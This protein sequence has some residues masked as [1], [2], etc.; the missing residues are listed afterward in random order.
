MSPKFFTANAFRKWLEKN[1]HKETEVVVGFYKVK[2]GKPSMSWSESVDEALCFGW[3]DG[4]RTSIDAESYKIRFTPR[5]AGSIWSAVN[6]RKM[7]ELTKAG[8][9]T[10][11]G[12]A[13]FEK[14]KDD[15]SAIYAHENK[16]VEFP[17]EIEKRFKANKKAW[18]YFQSLAPS[19]RKPSK[20]WVL[21]AKQEATR[22]K[23]LMKLIADSE[24]GIN[25]WKD[26]KYNKK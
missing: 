1:H 19:Y 20:N 14:R 2:S 18:Q 7:K 10:E 5:K 23:R 24:A 3:I 6:I 15:K 13:A 4:V 22:E 25:P 17:A 11:A 16:E 21:G 12:I 8:R 26:N 9:M